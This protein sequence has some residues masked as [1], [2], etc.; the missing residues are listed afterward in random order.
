[1]DFENLKQSNNKYDRFIYETIIQT[2]NR[3]GIE[4]HKNEFLKTYTEKK[5]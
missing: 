2:C 4:E 5:K 1:M 3:L